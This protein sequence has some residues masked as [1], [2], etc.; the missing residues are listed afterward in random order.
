MLEFITKLA[1]L[2]NNAPN[3]DIKELV[4][5]SKEREDGVI[6]SMTSP[7]EDG[8]KMAG[9]FAEMFEGLSGMLR[10]QGI[11]VI[12]SHLDREGNKVE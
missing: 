10:D 6:I 3:L 4:I 9:I 11:N 2:M 1:P 12:S 5:V 7:D 8:I